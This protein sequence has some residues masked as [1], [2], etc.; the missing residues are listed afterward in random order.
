MTFDPR[1][2]LGRPLPA[3]VAD[4]AQV[5]VEALD[6]T[7]QGRVEFYDAC[8]A[9]DTLRDEPIN[10][11]PTDLMTTLPSTA[12]TDLSPAHPDV[13][14]PDVVLETYLGGGSQGWVY[15]GRVIST[16]KVIAVKVLRGDPWAGL[17]GALR[18]ATICAKVRH[19]NIL[20]VFQAQPAGVFWV[21]HMEL[22]QGTELRP[23]QLTT[24]EAKTCFAQLADA[25]CT[26]GQRQIVH[27]DI[28]PANI[29]LR[30]EAGAPVLVDFGVAVDLAAPDL[31]PLD[32]SGTPLFMVAE[33]FQRC[34]PEPS[35]D[36]YS[37]GVSAAAALLGPL[38]DYPD[39]AAVVQAKLSGDF[40]RGLQDAL[41]Q[42]D[43]PPLREWIMALL[44]RDPATRLGALGT[45]RQ[46]VGG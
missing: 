45:A 19:P 43:D 12:D 44:S 34:H 15:A 37:L 8:A 18:E 17:R 25:L 3:V 9:R 11:R 22:V 23:G 7:G 32:V 1:Q 4:L 40:E 38:D 5:G 35:W 29:L 6:A 24:A 42:L 21:V 20:R 30:H 33:A 14:V 28:K 27:R 39:V 26:L 16:G 31:E 10:L 2:L 46:W 36:A 41:L 13:A